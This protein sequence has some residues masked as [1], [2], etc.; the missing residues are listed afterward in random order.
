M[1]SR[2]PG[3]DETK[4]RILKTARGLVLK[5]GHSSLSL[6]EIARRAGFGPASLYEY[7]DGKD[8]IVAALAR[9]AS[10]SLALALERAAASS[11]KSDRGLLVGLGLAYVAWAKEHPED[12]LLLFDRLPSKRKSLAEGPAPESPY[13]VVVDAVRRAAEAGAVRARGPAEVERLA[14]G[15]WATAHGMAMLQLTHL[16]SF[17]ASFAAADRAVLEAL[18]SGFAP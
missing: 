5:R 15:L 18:A 2:G 12:F 11:K 3:H 1:R 17:E 9:E 14:Y 7:F 13:R 6:R 10:A 16:A 4:Q 8:A